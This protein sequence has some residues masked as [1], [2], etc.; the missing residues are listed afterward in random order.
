MNPY[1]VLCDDFGLSAS[2]ASKTGFPQQRESILHFFETLQKAFPDLTE[3]DARENGEFALEEDREHGAYRWVNLER[4]RL[5]AGF[6]NPPSLEEADAQAVRILESAPYHLDL[7]A[8][9][10]E[11]LDVLFTFNF[12]YGGNHDEVV[13]EAL[14]Q[15]GALGGV[16]A[17][18]GVRVL[19][20]KPTVTLA[21]E[22]NCRLQC[23]LNVETRTNTYQVRTN[24]FPE[25]PISVYFTVRQYWGRMGK[26]TLA[27]AY[28][29][30]RQLGQ[31]LLDAHVVPAIIKP[32]GETIANKQ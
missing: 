7:A 12:L 29:R 3:F 23:Q 14:G 22:D 13:A 27:E 11:T 25:A 32:L 10:I 18:P 15:H 30:Q 17:L 4:N 16:L 31:E 2:V 5:G 21:L 26:T 9:D 28:R 20:Y 1:A 24:Q 19:D 8:L 6:V